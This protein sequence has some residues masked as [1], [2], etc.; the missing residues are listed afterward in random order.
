MKIQ[1]ELI[2]R[3]IRLSTFLHQQQK[4]FWPGV[5]ERLERITTYTVSNRREQSS[6]R[7]Q[8]LSSDTQDRLTSSQCCPRVPGLARSE[9]AL[10][11]QLRPPRRCNGGKLKCDSSRRN[12]GRWRGGYVRHGSVDI[13]F[14]RF[15]ADWSFFPM[16]SGLAGPR[17]FGKLREVQDGDSIRSSS[18]TKA[19]FLRIGSFL[20]KSLWD[21]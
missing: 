6:I 20:V 13:G 18:Q 3:S 17:Q 19:H 21:I 8:S 5:L 12:L 16:Y 4:P 7:N 9:S 1:S 2:T 15:R 14:P 11:R 10:Y